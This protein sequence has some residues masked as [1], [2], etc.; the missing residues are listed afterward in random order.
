MP[1]RPFV[2]SKLL[3]SDRRQLRTT[4]TVR[5]DVTRSTA[6][7]NGRRLFMSPKRSTKGRLVRPPP[8]TTISNDLLAALP[9]ANL[10]RVTPLLE[11]V[12][13]PVKKILHRSGR[14]IDYV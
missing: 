2:G 14:R 12:E 6:S 5:D 8:P 4:Y 13:L 9:R 1:A 3:V 7:H 10:R 11:I